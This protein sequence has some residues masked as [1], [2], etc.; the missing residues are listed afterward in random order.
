MPS[1]STADHRASP[2]RI[3]IPRDYNAAHD[4]IE[5]N[6]A[7]GRAGKIAYID[8]RGA[9][10]YG[11]LAE[12]VNR[13]AN[14]LAGLGLRPEERVL[15]L[16]SSTRSTFPPSSWARS[17]RASCRSRRTRCSRPP[18]TTTCCATAAPAR[19]SSR[20]RCCRRSR[21]SSASIRTCRDVI[22]SGAADEC[23]AAAPFA[24]R[25][26]GR[27]AAVV[28]GGRDDVRRRVLLALFVGIDG[29]AEGHRAPAFEPRADGRAL[30]EADSRHSRGRRRVLGG[31]ALLRL[32]A[33]QRA[34]VSARRRR[35]GGADG[36]A[37]DAGRG[38]RAPA[39]A[40]ADDLLRRADAVR[41]AAR[42]SRRC[43]SA[44]EL[45][46]RRCVVGGRG[47]AGGH[48]PALDRALRRRRFSTASARRRCCTSSCRIVRATCATARAARRCPATSCASSATTAS[49]SPPGEVGELQIK[50]PTAAMAYWNNR[51]KTRDTFQGPWT[52]S[53]D[54]YSVDA[55]GY[56]VYS[57]RSDDML[58]VG[59]IYVSPIE[60]ESALITHPAVLEAAV[61]GRADDEKLDQAA[62]VRRA[63]GGPARHAGAGRGAAPARQ[64]AARALQVSRAGSSSSTSFPRRQRVKSSASSCARSAS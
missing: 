36:R 14:A 28:R 18:T 33:R 45:A 1:L 8:D 56:Y 43:R 44:N 32:R 55:D 51:D 40:P 22:V 42:V 38:V 10:T 50:G 25:A 63:E 31:E 41:R 5:R 64:G 17:R 26:D 53:G 34:H 13:C 49:R 20:R 2:P 59:G 57:G 21:R 61:I 29:R 19:S 60:V 7:A 30:R 24:R 54:K 15:A 16:S 23:R 11:E 39:R 27:G 3:H 9:Y 6:L 47:A 46:L 62:G 12:R 58:K 52:R 35:D 48:R 37:A 4:L